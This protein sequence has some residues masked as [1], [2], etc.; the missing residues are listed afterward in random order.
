MWEQLLCV[1]TNN[2]WDSSPTYS[3]KP[4]IHHTQQFVEIK[5]N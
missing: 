1:G 3:N 4:E 5:I 2:A